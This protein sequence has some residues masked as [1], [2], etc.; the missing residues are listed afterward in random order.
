MPNM[1]AESVSRVL[2]VGNILHK[3]VLNSAV[4]IKIVAMRFKNL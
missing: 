3:G 4:G 1:P 2:F